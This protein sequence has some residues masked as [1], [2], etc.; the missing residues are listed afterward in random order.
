MP[1][2]I[3]LETKLTRPRLPT[4]LLERRRLIDRL[5]YEI[6]SSL[7]LVCAPAGFGKTTLVG[8][9]LEGISGGAGD[10]KPSM[11]SAWLSLD[12]KDSDLFLFLH[13]FIA[14]VR[15]IFD[16][17]CG[18]SLTLLQ[19]RQRIPQEVLF[20]TFSN[21]L[22]KLPGEMILVLDDYHTIQGVEIHN[23]LTELLHH[24][25]KPLH[26]VLITRHSPPL[27]LDRLRAKG[28]S[29]EIRTRDLRFSTEETADY[30]SKS[31]FA[32]M[33]PK[34]VSLLG[35]YEG[36][37]AGLHLAALSMR[38][39]ASQETVLSALT[40]DNSDITEYLVDEVLGH[41]DPAIQ[42]FLLKTSILDRFCV[43]LC[44]S[45]IGETALSW[46][47]RACL[48]W[49]ER[50]ELFLVPLDNNRTWYRYHHFFQELLQQRLY[51]EMTP[52]QIASMR[53]LASIWFDEHGLVDEAL[54]NA[55]AAGDL[56]LA[57][58]QMNAELCDV[59]N[60]EDR[61]ALERWM[62]LLPEKTIERKPEILILKAWAQQFT[63]RLDLQAQTLAKVEALLESGGG[64]SL[65]EDDLQILRGQILLM[66]AQQAYF[67]NQNTKV[68]DLCRQVLAIFP[69]SWTFVRGGA[70]MYLGMA[71]QASGQATR[72]ERLLLDEYESY[73]DKT[74]SYAL[75]LLLSLG[76]NYLNTGNFERA[77]QI[78]QVLLQGA[79]RSGIAIMSSWG[80]WFLGMVYYEWNKLETAVQH[81]SQILENRYTAQ[82]AAYR[83]AVAGMALIQ[84]IRG[85]SSEAWQ[86]LE[87]ISQFDLEQ[88]G[89]EE[90]RTRSLRARLMLIQGDLEG[91]SRWYDTFTGPP[92]N[93][94]FLWLEEPRVTRARVLVARGTDAD[95]RSAQEILDVL[96][97]IAERTHNTRFKIEI[98][99]LHALVLAEQGKT[100]EADAEL[101]QAVE[102]ARLGGFIR[103]FVDLGIPMQKMLYRISKQEGE[104]KGVRRILAAIPESDTPADRSASPEQSRRHA[105]PDIPSLAESL[106]PRELEVLVLLRE[107]LSIKDIACQ[108]NISYATAKRHTIHIY[109]KLEV[110]KRWDA[111]GRAEEL[112]IISP[113]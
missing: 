50:T 60:R 110:N 112:N 16:S 83:D 98:L 25:P 108:L 92:P 33:I 106:T 11:P 28:L 72:A 77:R 74:D 30:L 5:N 2:Q 97:A 111:V 9:W 31:Q 68:I 12:E 19:A 41:Q 102:L 13:Y 61:Q 85:E 40:G 67:G 104:V 100:R 109:G 22:G 55:L 27:P 57:A 94:P 63:W 49:V 15:K 54:Q 62:H 58:R 44:E 107:P 21:E 82:I 47:M 91:A 14:A 29:C 39:A 46:S 105:L 80:N 96:D 66:K 90:E 70:T 3:L 81:F 4:G 8:S 75:F 87:S 78:G 26:L 64:A 73:G 35:R 89:S 43:S 71:M 59:L 101:K 6:N 45:M 48:D 65:P 88:S 10:K 86:I 52:D 34:A 37:P 51:A 103:V 32:L 99:A 23:L 53:R 20:T 76:F 24:W 113:R 93:Q 42:T 84:Q 69:V 7:I 56:D 1:E 18:Q 79:T 36:W 95:L 17:A 38:S